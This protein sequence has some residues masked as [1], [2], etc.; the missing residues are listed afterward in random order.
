M[1]KPRPTDPNFEDHAIGNAHIFFFGLIVIF[2]L[3]VFPILVQQYF[4]A[5]FLLVLTLAA[6]NSKCQSPCSLSYYSLL[7]I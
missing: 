4:K 1:V 7:I 6:N 2:H 3:L 5:L